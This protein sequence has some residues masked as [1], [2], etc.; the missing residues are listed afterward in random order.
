MRLA[1]NPGTFPGASHALNAEQVIDRWT[2]GTAADRRDFELRTPIVQEVQAT[3]SPVLTLADLRLELS[4]KYATPQPS[5]QWEFD[6]PKPILVTEHSV[7][8]EPRRLLATTNYLQNRTASAEGISIHTQFYWPDR[9]GKGIIE[10]T[11]PLAKWKETT[12]QGLTT[13]PITLR[14]DFSQ[15]YRPGHHNFSEEFI[16][17]PALEAGLSQPVLDELKAANVQ[18]IHV[19]FNFENAQIRILGLDGKFRALNP[20]QPPGKP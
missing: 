12:I 15:T 20:V 4:V 5:L 3:Q 2:T 9:P 10:K 19:L 18:L 13:E 14:G 7:V 16:F 11:A 17:E 8:L 6:G 1:G